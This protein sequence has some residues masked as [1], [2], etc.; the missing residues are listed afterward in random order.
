ML[1]ADTL[2]YNGKIYNT[3]FK[4]F[5]EGYFSVKGDKFLHIGRG[6]VPDDLEYENKIDLGGKW[7]IPGLVDCH[8]HRKQH[9]SP[10]AICKAHGFK[11]RY[12]RCKRTP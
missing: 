2:F 11:R 6:D 1:K 3:V 5:I 10:E 8:M 12:Y 4:Q 7:V 9:D